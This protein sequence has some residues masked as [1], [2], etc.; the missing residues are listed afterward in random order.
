MLSFHY[1]TDYT[2]LDSGSMRVHSIDRV[3][4]SLDLATVP[5]FAFQTPHSLENLQVLIQAVE[6]SS[7][8]K[9]SGLVSNS[10]STT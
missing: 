7:K 4:Y 8:P 2:Q 6:Q 3:A 5:Y 9:Q 10:L 1:K